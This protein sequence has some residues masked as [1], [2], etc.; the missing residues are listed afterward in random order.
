MAGGVGHTGGLTNPRPGTE[1]AE[2]VILIPEDLPCPERGRL[3]KK[4]HTAQFFGHIPLVVR[5]LW[6]HE[7]NNL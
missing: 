1:D 4:R 2:P 7:S 5:K 6:W 3:F